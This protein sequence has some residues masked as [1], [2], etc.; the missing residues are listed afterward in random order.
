M[1]SNHWDDATFEEW[2]RDA[3]SDGSF[4]LLKIKTEVFDKA[5][6]LRVFSQE[7]W[8]KSWVTQEKRQPEPPEP[9]PSALDY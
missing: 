7:N 1:P 8:D 4:W 2:I 3:D 5:G 9:G 6:R